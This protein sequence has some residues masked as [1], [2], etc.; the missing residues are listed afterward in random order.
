MAAITIPGLQY[1]PNYLDVF[2]QNR[3]LQKIDAQTWSTEIKR[4]VQHY[5]YKYDYRK[6]KIDNTMALGN[7]PDW[8]LEI[9]EKLQSEGFMSAVADQVIV[10]EY[11]PG[12][13]ISPH[14]DCEPCFGDTIA[15][16]SLGSRCMIDFRH[17]THKRHVPILL[18][19]GSLLVFDGEARYHWT[20]GI[21]ARAEDIY[22]GHSFKRG[23]RVS[24][25]FRTI[26]R[27]DEFA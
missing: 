12:Q 6:R 5:G 2:Q 9:A 3:L 17:T 19:P 27:S 21:V 15:S 24:I 1:Q 20:H 11:Q 18:E 16:I 26:V 23:R 8:L 13:G 4:R 10:N 25:T 14:V 22:E 7:L